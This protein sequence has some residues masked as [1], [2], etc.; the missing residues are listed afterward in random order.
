MKKVLIIHPEGNIYNNPTLKCIVDLLLSEK[1]EV[2]IKYG[3]SLVPIPRR[4]GIKLYSYGR[5]HNKIRSIL[6]NKISIKSLV[7]IYTLITGLKY[8]DKFDYVIGVDRQGLIEGS[9]LSRY[10]KV[11]LIFIS[12]EIMFESETSKRFKSI[13][14]ISGRKIKYW[15]VQDEIR[16]KC[17]IDENN[18]SE[19]NCITL[20]LASAGAGVFPEKRLRDDLGIPKNKKVAILLGSIAN[21]TMSKEIVE[22][23]V[24]WPE[25]W[26][27]IVHSRYGDTTKVF[28]ELNI[29]KTLLTNKLFVSNYSSDMVDD[30]GYILNGVSVG[31]AF[32]KP[33]FKGPFTG[34]NIEFIGLSSGKIATFLRYGV[35]VIMNNINLYS[36]FAIEKIIGFVANTPLEISG[37]LILIDND[38]DRYRVN[39]KNLF[40]NKLDFNN[41][42]VEVLSKLFDY[43]I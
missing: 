12:F 10:R 14:R 21:W 23:I 7:D 27:L 26:V 1:I 16:K 24:N 33:D 4:D 42:R 20:P 31:M 37:Y 9:A 29:D 17:L 32:Y 28:A 36:Q 3:K 15:V 2:S 6:F 40:I 22:S 5:A 34:R 43:D 13:E 19:L 39:A 11:P 25:K 41:Y 35:P 18:I 30:M 8:A 38:E